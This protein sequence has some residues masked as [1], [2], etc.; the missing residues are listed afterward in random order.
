MIFGDGNIA[1]SFNFDNYCI[2]D[3]KSL[4]FYTYIS[5]LLG[6]KNGRYFIDFLTNLITFF[7]IKHVLITGHCYEEAS[8]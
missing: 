6:V 5:W 4:L 8:L 2:K 7:S 1:E 3:H